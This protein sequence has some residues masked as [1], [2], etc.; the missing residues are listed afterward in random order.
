MFILEMQAAMTKHYSLILGLNSNVSSEEIKT[1][2]RRRALDPHPGQ[3]RLEGGPFSP[4]EPARGLPEVSLMHSF[5]VYHPSFDELF[6]RFWSNFESGSRPKSER[7][8]S[9]TVEA[10]VSPEEAWWGGRVRVL[11]PARLPCRACAGQGA[12]GLYECWRCQGRGALTKEYPIDVDYPAELRDGY[13]VR[14]PLT[15]FGIENFYLTLLFRVGADR[16]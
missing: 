11:I 13:A 12:V 5:E 15:G 4:V 7:L 10:V 1:S 3:S 14:I 9:L 8:E 2:F 6:E 16:R